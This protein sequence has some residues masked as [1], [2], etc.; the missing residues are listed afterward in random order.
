MF[1]FKELKRSIVAIVCTSLLLTLTPHPLSIA[2]DDGDAAIDGL[3]QLSAG[4]PVYTTGNAQNAPDAA[5]MS[6]PSDVAVDTVGHRLFVADSGNNRVLVFDLDAS[7]HIT[8][9][10]ADYV[11]GQSS[12][13]GT[14]SA[15]TQSGLSS[16]KGLAYYNNKLY[17]SDNLNNRVVVYDVASISNGENAVSVLGQTL[18]TTSTNNL[19]QGGLSGPKGL[20][21]DTANSILF[22][23]DWANYRVVTFDVTAITDGENAVNVL[24]QVD[25]DTGAYT[26]PPTAAS[27]FT[28]SDVDFDNTNNTLYVLDS[29]NNRAIVHDF[30]VSPISDSRTADY[31]LGQAD[32]ASN[33]T[34][35]TQANFSFSSGNISYAG[36]KLYVA[37]SSA[38]RVMVFDVSTIVSG[39]NAAN[40]LG[41]ADFTSSDSAATQAGLSSPNGLFATSD[42]LFIADNSN[43]RVISQNIT[44]VSDG[45]AATSALGHLTTAGAVN[46]TSATTNDRP[47]AQGLGGI[48]GCVVDPTNNRVF[49]TDGNSLDNSQRVL[50]FDLNSSTKSLSDHTADNVLGQANLSAAVSSSYNPQ[51]NN[52]YDPESMVYDSATDYLFVSDSE[53]FGRILVFDLSGGLT[54]NMAATYVL[55]QAD[56]TT[57]SDMTVD[58]AG[59]SYPKG[60]D[61]ATIGSVKYLFV[62]DSDYNRVMIYDIDSI[63]NDEDAVKVIGQADFTGNTGGTTQST[64]SAP[65]DV[66]VDTSGATDYLYVSDYGNNRVMVYDVSDIAGMTNGPNAVAVIGQ[67]DYTSSSTAINATSLSSPW[68]LDVN[69]STGELFVS[70]SAHNR[71][72]VF[73]VS[74]L[75]EFSESAVNVLGQANFVSA[76]ASTTATTLNTPAGLCR[77]SSNGELYVADS[78]NYRYMVFDTAPSNTAPSIS[79]TMTIAQQN[80]DGYV[81]VA[82]TLTDAEADAVGL[83]AYEYSTDNASWSTMTAASLDVAHGGVTGLT[84]SSGGT[85]NTFVWDACT[86]LSVYDADVWVRFTPNDGTTAGSSAAGSASFA[87][88]C[89]APT[90][91]VV[92]A[93]QTASDDTVDVGYTLTDDTASGLTV[94]IDISED[95]GATWAVTDTSVTGNVG[96]SQTT[97][98]SKAIVWDAGTDFDGQDQSDLQVRL[99][100]TDAFQNVSTNY[101][102][103]DFALDTKD[104]ASLAWNLAS[105]G[106]TTSAITVAWTEATETNFAQYDVWY[107]LTESDVT[108]RSGSALNQ[109]VTNKGTTYAQITGLSSG[110]TY[111]FKMWASDSFGQEATFANTSYQTS[112]VSSSGGSSSATS[113]ASRSTFAS[114]QSSTESKSEAEPTETVETSADED[115]SDE[116]TLA[117]EKTNPL[118]AL[119]KEELGQAAE[120]VTE[121][122]GTIITT[123]PADKPN[124]NPSVPNVPTSTPTA[125]PVKTVTEQI[126]VQRTRE[127]V[128]VAVDSA[129]EAISDGKIATAEGGRLVKE[130]EAIIKG[131]VEKT[132][133]SGKKPLKIKTAGDEFEIKEDT[134]VIIDLTR[135]SVP[136]SEKK[137]NTVVITPS[138]TVNSTG[139]VYAMRRKIPLQA[140]IEKDYDGDGFSIDEEIYLGFDPEKRDPMSKLK[141]PHIPEFKYEETVAA[142]SGFKLSGP[143]GTVLKV[144]AIPL[145]KF[146]Q[147]MEEKNKRFS[148]FNASLFASVLGTGEEVPSD[149][150]LGAIQIGETTIDAKYKGFITTENPLPAGEYNLLVEDADG[151]VFSF[152]KIKVDEDLDSLEP[153]ITIDQDEFTILRP[154]ICDQTGLYGQLIEKLSNDSSK[155]YVANLCAEGSDEE[156]EPLKLTGTAEPGSTVF[157]TW[158]SVV[159][160]SVVIADAS[161]GKFEL[162]VLP[163]EAGEHEA[164]AYI[165]DSKGRTSSVKKITFRR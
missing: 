143:P 93:A 131:E 30:D 85:A 157:L 119:S 110:S 19:S 28:P 128:K 120:A 71:V 144:V 95:S 7:N 49:V 114:Q 2:F 115:K 61:I 11:L 132:V 101:P 81:N 116:E 147:Y 123:P 83:D 32:F 17:V 118:D 129:L 76:S 31:V 139:I 77:N 33:V 46:Y 18:F 6:S 36:D 27:L 41:Q 150:E 105:F 63:V 64:L 161:A 22:V 99:R 160:S 88:D 126:Q 13:S 3:G 29:G 125:T 130:A 48:Q 84:S 50:S 44:S 107:G 109:T 133:I 75:S 159:L 146:D 39:E 124:L 149:A 162:D 8:D 25:F 72:L 96:A 74:T 14:S 165:K 87:V 38:N 92:T 80:D 94:E 86:D 21:L 136:D 100:A 5:G 137:E 79:T 152:Y 16:P 59:L 113:A 42:R 68:G 156:S 135:S 69:A 10:T 104:P 153:E 112:S 103:S 67:A 122:I 51:N 73:N 141:I 91:S 111:Y 60:M 158:K 138:T 151:V 117:E 148:F 45:Q 134:K 98:S 145:K 34:S 62:A 163:T 37:D 9:Y 43:H 97:G 15:T 154:A 4:T 78:G 35:T 23:A 20:S 108:G 58:A 26:Y 24:G 142:K 54:D 127:E 102:S 57:W 121:V 65:T 140:I 55:G 47:N 155:L 1:K 66:V 70:D 89:G 12:F 52:V 40:V 82:Y 106:K 164:I 90:L 53:V 56:F